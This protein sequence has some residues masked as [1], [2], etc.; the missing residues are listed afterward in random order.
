M[1]EI[2]WRQVETQIFDDEDQQELRVVTATAEVRYG[3]AAKLL[4][5]PLQE[6]VE[7][8]VG[9]D[10]SWSVS[11]NRV[12]AEQPVP[13]PPSGPRKIVAVWTLIEPLRLAHGVMYRVPASETEQAS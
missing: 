1:S 6:L 4:L 2:E 10:G 7:A 11:L 12:N 8:D 5:D 9:V 3:R 13:L